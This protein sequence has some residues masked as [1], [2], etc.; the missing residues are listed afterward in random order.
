[1]PVGPCQGVPF[2]VL[3]QALSQ[4][5]ARLKAVLLMLSA[6]NEALSFGAENQ[7]CLPSTEQQGALLITK[8]KRQ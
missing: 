5:V 3:A 6:P 8:D 7:G 2:Q 4:R 1:M